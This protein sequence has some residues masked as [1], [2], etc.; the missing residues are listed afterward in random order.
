MAI[1]VTGGA[2]YIGSHTVAEL[3]DRGYEVVVLDNLRQGHRLA[4]HGVPLYEGDIADR[5]LVTQVIRS[6]GIDTVVH[7]AA[8]SLVGE[9]VQQPL[10]YYE[11]N[12]CKT[13]TLLD[14]L[15]TE[16][17]LRIVFSSTAAT[18]GEPVEVPIAE[19]HPTVPTN[20]YGDTKLAIERMLTSC[21]QAYGL[22]S[23]SLR[24]FNAAG[25][26]HAL[27]IGE[28][29]LPETHLIP[30]VVQAA[31][32]LR[33]Q[34]TVFG[35][36]Y[37]TPDGTCVRDYVHVMDL[38]QAHR[39]AVERLRHVEGAEVYNLGNGKG[40]TVNEVIRMVGV[41]TGKCV[42]TLYGPRRAG[43]P[44]VLVAS[45]RRAHDILGWAPQHSDLETIIKSA[46]TWHQSHPGGFEE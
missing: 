14:T 40:F 11:A 37:D 33:E 15:V 2:G 20:P 8:L 32:G 43:D 26:H 19:E 28:N 7:F 4:I 9:S 13:R 6:H 21:Y 5:E 22:S 45:S 31:L 42:P 17:V 18:Y 34:I 10:D 16:K 44:A 38:A 36:D 27:P 12:V 24:Y 25:A 41:A 1:L 39:L 35:T 29:H 46:V 23:I 30:L 3:V